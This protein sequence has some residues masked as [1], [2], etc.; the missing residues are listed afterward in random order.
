MPVTPDPWST[1]YAASDD[2]AKP[3]VY[4]PIIRAVN[5]RLLATGNPFQFD[6][7]AAG[8]D[9]LG[10]DTL[11][12]PS[13]ASSGGGTYS[14]T[15]PWPLASGTL[16]TINSGSGGTYSCT[17]VNYYT[18]TTGGTVTTTRAAKVPSGGAN[19][20]TG[21]PALVYNWTPTVGGSA[22]LLRA[23]S[24]EAWIYPTTYRFPVESYKCLQYAVYYLATLFMPST[25]PEGVAWSPS[26]P[27]NPFLP[28][29]PSV[30]TTATPFAHTWP[31]ASGFPRY[32]EQ[33]ISQL[34]AGGT[35]GQR[36]RFLYLTSGLSID[37]YA[38]TPVSLPASSTSERQYSLQ[39]MKRASGAWVVDTDQTT[40]P[41][42][43][44]YYGPAQPGDVFDHRFVNNL[45]AAIDLLS[46]TGLRYLDMPANGLYWTQT[47]KTGLLLQSARDTYG[48]A[49]S[50][51]QSNWSANTPAVNPAS[52]SQ[53]HNN[54]SLWVE[55]VVDNYGFFDGLW[56]G[57]AKTYEAKLFLGFLPTDYPR[58]VQVYGVGGY[59]SYAFASLAD[60]LSPGGAS[61][62]DLQF[63]ANGYGLHEHEW[64][65]IAAEAEGTSGPWYETGTILGSNATFPAW[66]TTTPILPSG[67]SGTQQTLWRGAALADFGVRV[68]WDFGD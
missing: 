60:G 54:Q 48:N 41:D 36:A 4:L 21:Y 44:T 19:T 17:Y 57:N 64:H 8:R 15:R 11:G 2:C 20:P 28:Y 62:N 18:N 46:V 34:S 56:Y 1:V 65:L 58:A 38:T 67:G 66:S 12:L 63:D 53:V 33:E 29:L 16:V 9:A 26:S 51:I 27:S 32:R 49:Q 10:P 43:V 50:T 35:N 30:V 7:A 5:K 40:P 25:D 47:A 13:Y 55:S 52:A 68:L 23:S 59:R 45:K 61:N 31:P 3:E 6:E 14:L 24:T 39:I 42:E 22:I 37:P